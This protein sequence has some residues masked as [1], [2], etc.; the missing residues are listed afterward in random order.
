MERMNQMKPIKLLVLLVL[1][2]ALCSACSQKK[3]ELKEIN[4]QTDLVSA[5]DIASKENLPLV[6]VFTQAKCPWCQMLDD[7]TFKNNIIVDMSEKMVFVKISADKDSALA[8]QFGVAYYPTI[9]VCKA[10][11]SEIDRLVGYFPPADFYNEIQLYL[12][13]RETIDDFLS[14]LKD[15]PQKIEYLL[16]VAE[17]YR[18]RSD[19]SKALEY[20]RQV[21]TLNP[22]DTQFMQEALFEEAIMNGERGVVDTLMYDTSIV[23]LTN[24]IA[25]SPDSVKRQDAS[26]R[27]PFYVAKKG[28]AKLAMTL[29]QKYLETYP[30]GEY[31]N[32]VKERLD[33]LRNLQP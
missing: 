28:D 2:I 16:A 14:R 27:L 33:E 20:Y 12:Q 19:W 31:V 7:S 6:I 13:D 3:P 9:M 5:K 30:N 24:F 8:R 32:W 4:F 26:R 10:N 23:Q 18:N 22:P 15:E 1:A 11:G 29:Y 21:I 25:N 17:K